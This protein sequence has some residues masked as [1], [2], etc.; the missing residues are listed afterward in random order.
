MSLERVRP[1]FGRLGLRA[2]TATTVTVAGT[3]GKGSCVAYLESILAAA[4]YRTGVYTSPHLRQFNER[5]RVAG[6][7]A[8]DEEIVAAFGKVEAAR[9]DASLTYFE[10][11]TL[12]A[13]SVFRA[14]RVD[15]CLLEVGMGGRL[16]AVNLVDADISVITSIGLDHQG[17]LGN[18]RTAI[19]RE[20]AGVFRR[21]QP[22]IIGESNPPE[23]IAQAA[24]ET[25]CRLLQIGEDF[26]YG[27]DADSWHWHGGA[28]QFDR[29]PPPRFGGNE[30][31][32]NASCAL[33]VIEQLAVNFRTDGAH[34]C[35]GLDNAWLPGRLQQVAGRRNWILDVAHNGEA[36]MALA[37]MLGDFAGRTIAVIGMMN[38]KPVEAIA[39]ALATAVDEWIV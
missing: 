37:A 4:G 26:S 10:Y 27:R 13:L 7:S 3:N 2:A 12:A 30:Q 31:Y 34:I 22:A 20:K 25:G 28:T 21:D 1:V 14:Q 18:D 39:A 9:L 38:D 17:W 29:L 11:S 6:V 8:N 5:I 19:A 35:A 36:A 32:A 23:S 24:E 16:D 33:A 15:I